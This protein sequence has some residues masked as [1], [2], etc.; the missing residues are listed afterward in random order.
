MYACRLRCWLASTASSL[1]RAS[2]Q[3]GERRGVGCT[4]SSARVDL[5]WRGRCGMFYV[6]CG[7]R[8]ET[9]VHAYL[10]N[11]QTT[12]VVRLSG[13]VTRSVRLAGVK[14][15]HQPGLPLIGT[16]YTRPSS[17][18]DGLRGR[19]HPHTATPTVSRDNVGQTQSRNRGKACKT[20]RAQEG[21]RAQ[22]AAGARAQNA[23]LPSEQHSFVCRLHTALTRPL[24][25]RLVRCS[26]RCRGPRL[27]AHRSQS[28]DPRNRSRFSHFFDT[29]YSSPTI[30]HSSAW[31][32]LIVSISIRPC[33]QTERCDFRQTQPWHDNGH[34]QRQHRHCYGKVRPLLLRS[35]YGLPFQ[36]DDTTDD[37]RPD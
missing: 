10:L 31:P 37:T 6:R 23:W 3:R 34:V 32:V 15:G 16:L 28:Q 9:C 18:K 36:R 19:T 24:V 12:E 30:L 29:R 8:G 13:Y 21:Q 2:C 33:K 17:R 26:T 35:A 7:R 20:R 14:R 25:G 27:H 4:P 5:F 1:L 22:A 11:S